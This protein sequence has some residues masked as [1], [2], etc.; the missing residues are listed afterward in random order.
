MHKWLLIWFKIFKRCYFPF[1]IQLSPELFSARGRP[2]FIS[3]Y[4]LL[5]ITHY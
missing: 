1:R 4:S 2:K 5:T 3:N